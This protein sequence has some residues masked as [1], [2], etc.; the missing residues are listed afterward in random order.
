[1]KWQRNLDRWIKTNTFH[2]SRYSD[3]KNLVDLKE[4]KGL[5]ISLAF[6]T[7]NE[8]ETIG[9]EIK[10]IREELQVRYP[11]IDEIA[12]IDSGSTDNTREIA[13][14]A[15]ADVYLASD[16]LPEYGL[17]RGK[18]ENLWKSLYILD[19]DIILWLDAD[20]KN[21]HP[22]FAYGILGPL[23][24]FDHIHYVKGFYERPIRLG[25]RM[26][27][28][29]GGRV[30]EIL[31]RPLLSNFYPE[32]SGFLQPLSGEYA[33]RRKI[34]EQIPF[35]VGYGVEIGLLIDIYERFGLFSMAQ[36]DLD[37]RI[38]RNRSLSELGRM[39]FAILHT[40]FTRLQ[41]QR[42]ISLNKKIEDY[43][44]LVKAKGEDIFLAREKFTFVER[45]PMIEIEEYR[46]KREFLS[47]E[48][49]GATGTEE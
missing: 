30:T 29:G 37:R 25:K 15:G 16:Y 4:K 23:L 44:N 35:R 43:F 14:E 33:G 42:I 8:E 1:M 45:S 36:V 3:I 46:E 20:I 47:A 41:Q 24:E 12:I 6:P 9:K 48:N 28:S 18:G 49:L 19:G 10:I 27:H 39:S 13:Q 11:L 38:H 40:F 21:I 34:L 7:L 32:L 26:R 22:K 31:V 17:I 5:K 2:H